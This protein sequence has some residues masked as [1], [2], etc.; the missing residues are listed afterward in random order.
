MPPNAGPQMMPSD[1]AACLVLCAGDFRRGRASGARVA[2]SVLVSGRGDDLR[3][4]QAAGQAMRLAYETS[5]VGPEDLDVAEVYD[6]TPIHELL[7][8]RSMGL[9]ERAEA[10]RLIAERVTWLG[11]RLPVNP[12]GGLL[13]RG[14][15][16]GAA[17]AA[18]VVELAWQLQGRCGR[19]QVSSPKLAL[20]SMVG[21]WLGSDIASCAVHMLQV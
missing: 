11:G 8:Y 1:G 2:A 12:S 21:G 9:C 18:Q 6:L 5:G 19:R 4:P 17:G 20:A 15:P 10:A 14:H 3:Q 7:Q 13:A 16:M